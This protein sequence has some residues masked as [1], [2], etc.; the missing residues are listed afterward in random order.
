[1]ALQ[2]KSHGVDD[3]VCACVCA[4][5]CLRAA[6]CCV[7]LPFVRQSA[8]GESRFLRYARVGFLPWGWRCVP[9]RFGLSDALA[10]VRTPTYRVQDPPESPDQKRRVEQEAL[11]KISHPTCPRQRAAFHAHRHPALRHCCASSS[12]LSLHSMSLG[13][14]QSVPATGERMSSVAVRRLN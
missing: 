1:M 12:S 7:F 14:A 10:H 5:A 8:E 11:E 9:L 6:N 13:T 3:S 4:R 2:N